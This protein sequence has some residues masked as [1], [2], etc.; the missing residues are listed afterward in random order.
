LRDDDQGPGGFDVKTF[1]VYRLD[2]RRMLS[3]PVG[4]LVERRRKERVNNAADLL[5]WA[6]RVFPPYPPDSHLVITPE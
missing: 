2:Y 3:E 6:E 1:I 5:K 4:K